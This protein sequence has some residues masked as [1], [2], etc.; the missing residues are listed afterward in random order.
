MLA[1]K[2]AE[3]RHAIAVIASAE[4]QRK[5][6]RMRPDA[7]DEKDDEKEKMGKVGK[8]HRT[9]EEEDH[10]VDPMA[11]SAENPADVLRAIGDH[12]N[13]RLQK[14][15]F[16]DDLDADLFDEQ[17]RQLREE[18]AIAAGTKSR[19]LSTAISG[20]FRQQEEQNKSVKMLRVGHNSNALTA[21]CGLGSEL[22]VFGDKSGSVYMAELRGSPSPPLSSNSSQKTLLRPCLP[23]AVLSIAV[24]D[25]S[26]L[27]PSQR[28]LF[29]R[30]TVDTSVTSY[31]AAGGADG[32]ISIWV[33]RTRKHMG[34]LSM[35]RSAVTGLAFRHDTLYSCSSDETLRV[36]SVPQMICQ[37]KLFGH[38]GRV[39]GIHCLKRERCATVGEDGTMRFWKVDAATQQEFTTY[40]YFGVKVV[41]E[42]VTMV[43]ENVVL[44]GASNGALLLYDLNKRKPLAV[45]EAAHGYGF[46]GDGTGLEKVILAAQLEKA[47]SNGEEQREE[48]RRNANPITAVASIPYSDVAASASYDGNVRLWRI[49]TPETG[50]KSGPTV[51]QA[52]TGALARTTFECLA[53]VPISAIVTSLYFTSS[54]D[55]L[56]LGCGKEPRLGR[57]VVQR[58]ALN[59]AYVV[60]L[61]DARLRAFT[62]CADVEHIPAMLYGFDDEEDDNHREEK[63]DGRENDVPG[64]IDLTERN[65][66][67]QANEGSDNDSDVGSGLFTLGEDGQMQFL[68]PPE[69]DATD[70]TAVVK[71]KKK[72]MKAKREK[73]VSS[74]G[75]GGNNEKKFGRIKRSAENRQTHQPTGDSPRPQR[76]KK[77]KANPKEAKE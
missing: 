37:D 71:K 59:A 26:G 56:F 8:R 75:A 12:V 24:S 32:T 7:K 65:G 45:Q 77:K 34:F 11:V 25:T 73:N 6:R 35:H 14:L 52:Q 22:V 61:D 70:E 68:V 49:A 54:G 58:S 31:I 48:C 3:R 43:N 50:K 57:W 1:K 63:D 69:A 67:L 76:R 13:T 36:W 10:T 66:A 29:E 16:D 72:A 46:V 21:V 64:S 30:S 4:R 19:V 62:A 47:S 42:C 20:F 27:R 53:S 33:T 60:P 44:C 23:A 17:Q 5:V 9:S 39:L 51:D 55:A 15:E 40:S 2:K 41:L 38:Q 18:A 74:R 28:A